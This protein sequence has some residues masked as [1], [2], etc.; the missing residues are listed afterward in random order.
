MFHIDLGAVLSRNDP[1]A[2]LE[3]YLVACKMYCRF[4]EF[5]DKARKEKP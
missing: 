5:Y 2:A 1:A 3:E 4:C